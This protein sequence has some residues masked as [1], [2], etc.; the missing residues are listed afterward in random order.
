MHIPDLSEWTYNT[1]GND[2]YQYR[3]VGWL[4][5]AVTHPGDT[6]PTIVATL[7]FLWNVNQLPD[8]YRGLHTCEICGENHDKG[9]FF[10]EDQAVRFVLPNMVLHYIEAHH[11]RLP[12]VVEAAVRRRSQERHGSPH[13]SPPPDGR[14]GNLWRRFVRLMRSR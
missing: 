11:Y 10:V 7:R 12:D 5:G 2:G 8:D 9:E 1:H 13:D 14:G 6:D 4:G 3:S